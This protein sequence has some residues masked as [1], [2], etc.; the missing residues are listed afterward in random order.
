VNV[1][2]IIKCIVKNKNAVKM[3]IYMHAISLY[4][5]KIKKVIT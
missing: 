1:T 4:S 3:E 5:K 2:C